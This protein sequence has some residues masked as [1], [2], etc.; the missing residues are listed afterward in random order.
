MKFRDLLLVTLV[1]V[2]IAG[3]VQA[4]PKFAAYE[5]KNATSEGEGGNK[6]TVN[7]IDFWENGA[8][9]RKFQ[10]LG[11]LTD[12]RHATG[13]VGMVR[14]SGLEKDIAAAAKKAG[15]DA[16]ILVEE[17]KRVVGLASTGNRSMTGNANATGGFN[18]NSFSSGF[19][20]PIAKHDAE[21]T[22]VKYLPQDAGTAPAAPAPNPTQPGG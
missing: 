2:S 7:G 22:V 21:Y 9:P 17:G 4:A 15:G 12:E 8:P 10:V 3:A 1:G 14:M 13:L 5:G 11:T 20:A 6:T 18:A 16:V 19:V